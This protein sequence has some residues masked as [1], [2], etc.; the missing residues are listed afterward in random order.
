MKNPIVNKLFLVF[1][2]SYLLIVGLISYFGEIDLFKLYVYIVFY[3]IFLVAFFI[4]KKIRLIEYLN[5]TYLNQVEA[6][7]SITSAVKFDQPFSIL[8]N[9]GSWPDFLNNILLQIGK[10]Q[11]KT[12][13]ELGS[14]VSTEIIGSYIQSFEQMKL[15]SIEDDKDYF[16]LNKEKLNSK[17]ILND[18]VELRLAPIQ[19][20]TVDESSFQW[21][22]LEKFNDIEEIDFLIV[23]GPPAFLQNNSRYPAIPILISK[24]NS[25]AIVMLD[26]Y[27]RQQESSIVKKWIKEY[28][29]ELV[30]NIK[31]H[32][33]LAVLKKK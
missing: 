25:G 27:K 13:V 31:T 29:L 28:N 32:K 33:G 18:R 5:H 2:G 19:D 9:Y 8:V 11:P 30:S 24:M 15:I 1:S 21:Y 14:G 22:E 7:F 3:L 4:Y 20:I 6:F 17:N 12:I 23:D 16:E 10:K 26:D